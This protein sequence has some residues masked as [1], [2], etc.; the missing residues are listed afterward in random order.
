[1]LEL[2]T[3]FEVDNYRE[4][5]DVEYAPNDLGFHID[6]IKEKQLIESDMRMTSSR[7]SSDIDALSEVVV[8][9]AV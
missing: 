7:I 6:R 8:E 9:D 4:N 1:M 5:Q 2:L 3:E